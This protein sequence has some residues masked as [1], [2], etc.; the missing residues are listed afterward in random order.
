MSMS[1]PENQETL[2]SREGIA[3][4]DSSFFLVLCRVNR[5]F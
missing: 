1:S 2:R 3:P 4:L 5:L